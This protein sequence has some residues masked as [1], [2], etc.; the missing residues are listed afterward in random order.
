MTKFKIGD[1]VRFIGSIDGMALTGP[2]TANV[3]EPSVLQA[4]TLPAVH[5]LYV[6]WDRDSEGY[7]RANPQADGGYYISDFELVTKEQTPQEL[8][9]EFRKNYIRELE[10]HKLL[11]ESGFECYSKDVMWKPTYADSSHI[12]FRRTVSEVI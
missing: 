3:V 8:A 7:D 1:K 9:D 12:S 2:A 10:I 11:Q 5:F 6:R 4:L